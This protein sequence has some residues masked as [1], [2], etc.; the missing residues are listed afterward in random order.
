[1]DEP[2]QQS[3]MNTMKPIGKPSGARRRKQRKERR[4]DAVS[5]GPRPRTMGDEG[6]H[7]R[8]NSYWQLCGDKQDGDKEN[9]GLQQSE[10]FLE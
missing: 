2:L 5:K 9:R 10:K 3:I 4:N 8:G 7:H 6:E 1:V